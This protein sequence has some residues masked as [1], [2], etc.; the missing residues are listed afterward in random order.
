MKGWDSVGSIEVQ[1]STTKLCNKSLED[2][3]C[4]ASTAHDYS[5]CEAKRNIFTEQAFVLRGGALAPGAASG[6]PPG[7]TREVGYVVQ[8]SKGTAGA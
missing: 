4:Y 6:G 1:K 5:W 7:S 2:S 8:A 3:K